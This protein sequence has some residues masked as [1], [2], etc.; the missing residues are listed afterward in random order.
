MKRLAGG[1]VAGVPFAACIASAACEP[2]RAVTGEPDGAPVAPSSATAA[3]ATPDDTAKA[4]SEASAH[5]AQWRGAL[6]TAMHLPCRAIAVDGTVGVEWE[7]DAGDTGADAGADRLVHNGEIPEGVWLSI[8]PDARL[9][10][11]DPRTTR[12][13]TFLGPARVRPCVSHR[14][15]SWIASGSFE[16]AVGAGETPGAEEWVVTPLAV[17]RYLAAKL[18]VDVRTAETTVSLAGGGAFLWLAD[19]VREPHAPRGSD[20]GGT[21]GGAGEGSTT[22]DDEGWHRTS[23]TGVLKL[24]AVATRT[25]GD[26]ARSA[27]DRC[28]ALTRRARELAGKL[29]S[30]PADADGGTAKEQLRTRRLA[31]AACAVAAMRVAALA[32][33]PSR[34]ALSTTLNGGS[35]DR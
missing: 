16:S 23:D 7:R 29:I 33:S 1:W 21:G 27:I 20:A 9:V 15:E 34:D 18:R 10:A 11:K 32:P 30:E 17:V 2:Q 14:E 8:A 25:P 22:I 3:G 24:T 28:T 6:T 13:T 31:R 5:A 35:L 19:D 26:A 4:S 12:E